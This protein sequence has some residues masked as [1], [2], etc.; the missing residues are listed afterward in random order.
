MAEYNLD[1]TKRCWDCHQVYIPVDE[2]GNYVW[3]PDCRDKRFR[4]KDKNILNDEFIQKT[5]RK[6]TEEKDIFRLNFRKEDV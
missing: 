6:Y 1:E 2:I 3:C 5:V 4:K